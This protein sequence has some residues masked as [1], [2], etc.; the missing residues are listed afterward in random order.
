[1]CLIKE[2][3]L[4]LF[5]LLLKNKDVKVLIIIKFANNLNCFFNCN[6]VRS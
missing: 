5:S 1:M 3:I 4:K 6:L 2:L